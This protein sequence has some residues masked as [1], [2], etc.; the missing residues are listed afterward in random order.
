MQD[1]RNAVFVPAYCLP[2]SFPYDVEKKSG[3]S[4]FQLF[5][6][7]IGLLWRNLTNYLGT[8]AAAIDRWEVLRAVIEHC[9]AVM[10]LYLNFQ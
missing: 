9:M 10:S 4:Y 8:G 1:A 5:G 6:K 3:A 7:I 2:T